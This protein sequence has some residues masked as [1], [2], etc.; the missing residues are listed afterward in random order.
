MTL[1]QKIKLEHIQG[2][3]KVTVVFKTGNLN[4]FKG[5]TVKNGQSKMHILKYYF[6][7]NWKCCGMWKKIHF[8]SSLIVREIIFHYSQDICPFKSFFWLDMLQ[9]GNSRFAGEMFSYRVWSQC[10]IDQSCSKLVWTM[11]GDQ[12]L[13]LALQCCVMFVQPNVGYCS[14]CKAVGGHFNFCK[15]FHKQWPSSLGS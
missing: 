14:D 7:D 3:Y 5:K 8:K 4:L 11:S 9:I 15:K 10:R 2:F 13:F 12:L 6:D 1:T